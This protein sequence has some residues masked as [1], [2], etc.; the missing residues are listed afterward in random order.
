MMFTSPGPLEGWK[1][2]F[3]QARKHMSVRR[4]KHTDTRDHT[5]AAWVASTFLSLLLPPQEKFI[6]RNNA[7]IILLACKITVTSTVIG[8]PLGEWNFPKLIRGQSV[9]YIQPYTLY[10]EKNS[11]TF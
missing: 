11:F 1:C 5:A 9:L 10:L 8:Q 7:V 3:F 2:T 6:K 4:H